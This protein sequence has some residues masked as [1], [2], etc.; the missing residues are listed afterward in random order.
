MSWL[1]QDIDTSDYTRKLDRHD[2][3]IGSLFEKL[4]ALTDYL[5]VEVEYKEAGHT[6]KKKR[7]TK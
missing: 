1:T 5:G 4:D 3:Y 7:R 2:T 6:I